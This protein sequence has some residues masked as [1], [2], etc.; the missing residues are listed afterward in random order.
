MIKSLL[1][2]F[3]IC[4]PPSR[5][6]ILNLEIVGNEKEAKTKDA[7]I[8]IKDKNNIF[9][10]YNTIKKNHCAISFNLNDSI[11]KS[12]SKK[13]VDILIDNIIELYLSILYKLRFLA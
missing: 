12:Y 5:N 7:A 6:E 11:I 2:T 8:Y 9:I 10:Y 3:Y 4:F 1:L 13:Y